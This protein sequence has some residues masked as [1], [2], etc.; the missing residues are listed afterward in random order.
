MVFQARLN[1]ERALTDGWHANIGRKNFADAIAPAETIE[2]GFGEEDGFVFAAFDFA[3]ARIHVTAEFA[4]IEIGPRVANLRLPA[5]AAG[6]DARA[7]TKSR[8]RLIFCG[9]EAIAGVFAAANYREAEA[10]RN[11]GGNVFYVVNGK[12]DFFV[13]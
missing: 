8:E 7:L 10:R 12:I 5:K 1:A 3:Q 11:F 9:N 2:S 13:Q 4:Q 6:T